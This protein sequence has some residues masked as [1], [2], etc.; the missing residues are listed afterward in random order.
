MRM[1]LVLNRSD[2]CRT[3]PKEPTPKPRP[4]C[5]IFTAA[6]PLGSNDRQRLQHSTKRPFWRDTKQAE[7][8]GARVHFLRGRWRIPGFPPRLFRIFRL[9][10]RAHYNTLSLAG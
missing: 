6:S 8:E 3:L 4:R 10:P 5:G 1:F 9:T 7:L 2:A